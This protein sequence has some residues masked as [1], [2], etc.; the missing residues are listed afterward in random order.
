MAEEQ[1]PKHKVLLKLRRNV[2]TGEL[3]LACPVCDKEQPP[4]KRETTG[5]ENKDALVEFVPGHSGASS[6]L[7]WLPFRSVEPLATLRTLNQKG[8]DAAEIAWR[9]RVTAFCADRVE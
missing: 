5:V 8:V 2:K 6:L 4:K 1:C 3:A 9:N 7:A